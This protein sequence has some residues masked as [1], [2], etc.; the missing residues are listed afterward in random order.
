MPG[1]AFI[2]RIIPKDLTYSSTWFGC[3]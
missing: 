1:G 2:N 3:R